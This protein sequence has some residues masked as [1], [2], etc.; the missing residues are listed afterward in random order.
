M[1]GR[2]SES[3]HPDIPSA[4]PGGPTGQ[5]RGPNSLGQSGDSS[6]GDHCD[7]EAHWWSG[8]ALPPVLLLSHRDTTAALHRNALPATTIPW[9]H[10]LTPPTG[11]APWLGPLAGT[12]LHPQTLQEEAAPAGS[13]G[14][15]GQV[16]AATSEVLRPQSPL[17]PEIPAPLERLRPLLQAAA[18]SQPES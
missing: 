14:V 4:C 7:C 2:Q 11:H 1:S 12:R 15:K 17:R 9:L 6:G 18:V 5:S 16:Q 13:A 3:R 8:L 10:P